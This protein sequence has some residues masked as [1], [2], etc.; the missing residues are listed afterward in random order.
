MRA[1]RLTYPACALAIAAAAGYAGS[2]IGQQQLVAQGFANCHDL[3][4]NLTSEFLLLARE[5]VENSSDELII[6]DDGNGVNG[7]IARFRTLE[8]G[9]I[10]TDFVINLISLSFTS[11]D[12]ARQVYEATQRT[13][14]SL[15][16]AHTLAG[17]NDTAIDIYLTDT[18]TQLTEYPEL[19]PDFDFNEYEQRFAGLLAERGLSMDAFDYRI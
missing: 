11:E 16:D 5:I 15:T 12:L 10:T 14:C 9:E 19:H 17:V 7:A 6:L 2:Q 3:D 8:P 13:G 18:F 1:N 4:A